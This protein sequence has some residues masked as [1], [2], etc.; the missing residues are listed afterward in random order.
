MRLLFV[1]NSHT[2]VNDMPEICA[3]LARE[4]GYPCDAVMLAYPGWYLHQHLRQPQTRFNIRYG[5]YDYV[6]VQEH[7][8][9]FDCLDEYR[10]AV[11]ELC[12]LIREAG[13]R[14]VL[15]G[16]WA[17]LR[18]PEVGAFMNET[19]RSV[20][21]ENGMLLAPVGESW[22]CEAASYAADGEHASPAGSALAARVIWETIK[23]DWECVSDD[24]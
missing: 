14:P 8:H 3:S 13:S 21:S 18:D 2:Y 22:T 24:K 5:K 16:T 4:D 1:G 12:A 20:A 23:N 11:K 10:A 7:A 17:P 9:P 6:V 15:Y 19:H